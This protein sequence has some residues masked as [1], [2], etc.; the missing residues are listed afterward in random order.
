MPDS[1]TST[2]EQEI[3]ISRTKTDPLSLSVGDRIA[4]ERRIDKFEARFNQYVAERLEQAT[5][6]LQTRMMPLE[7]AVAGK[8]RMMWFMAGVLS[9]TVL[10]TVA[11]LVTVLV[12]R[13]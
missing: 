6:F 1:S 9:V 4:I 7:T 12:T 2:N 5:T 13:A 8:V 11:T 10:V 3:A